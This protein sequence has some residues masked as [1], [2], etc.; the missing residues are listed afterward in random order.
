MKKTMTLLIALIIYSFC[1]AQDDSKVPSPTSRAFHAYRQYATTPPYGV[2]K[3]K[4]LIKAKTI[5]TENP[6]GDDTGMDSLPEKLYRSLSLREKF[7]YNMIYGESYF[8]S[9]DMD[10]PVFDEEK[11]IFGN[12]P[13]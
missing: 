8:Q 5:N 3:V 12:L 7:T 13:R 4:H 6:D 1:L 9:C 10:L 11:K 2:E